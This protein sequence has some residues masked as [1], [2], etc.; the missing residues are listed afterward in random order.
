MFHTELERCVAMTS[1]GAFC[2]KGDM[3]Y[4]FI[5]TFLLFK[6][7]FTSIASAF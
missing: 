1:V 4:Y 3:I 7:T 2:C 5:H 6:K